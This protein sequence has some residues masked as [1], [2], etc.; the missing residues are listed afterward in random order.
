[1]SFNLIMHLYIVEFIAKVF[2]SVEFYD[3]FWQ[4]WI[5]EHFLTIYS[6]REEREYQLLLLYFC[7]SCRDYTAGVFAFWAFVI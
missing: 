2:A 6:T 7:Q 4:S 5:H 3:L 1:M